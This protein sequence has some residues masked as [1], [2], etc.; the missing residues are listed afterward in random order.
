IRIETSD[1]KNSLFTTPDG[2]M[3]S[4]V[5]HQGDCNAGSTY[6]SL[7]NHIVGPYLSVF[8]DIYLDDILLISSSDEKIEQH[9]NF[10]IKKQTD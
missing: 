5:M 7:M 2:T 1:V 8:M 6:Q 10:Y 9:A 4:L 3:E